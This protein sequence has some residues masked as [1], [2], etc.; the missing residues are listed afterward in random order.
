MQTLENG[1][2]TFPTGKTGSFLPFHIDGDAEKDIYNPSTPFAIGDSNF[3]LARVEGARSESDSEVCLFDVNSHYGLVSR[4]SIKNMQDPY[5]LGQFMVNGTL[6]SVFGGV[7]IKVNSVGEVVSY[8]DIWYACPTEQGHPLWGE[9]LSECTEL[10][11]VV[12]GIERWKDTRAVQLQD[13]VA[14]FPRPQGD[15]G[16]A[17]SI[18]YFE[19]ASLQDVNDDL[20]KYAERADESSLLKGI[21]NQHEWGGVNQILSYDANGTFTLI[22]HRARWVERDGLQVRDYEAIYFE[23]N[24]YTKVV[25]NVGVIATA[26]DFAPIAPKQLEGQESTLGKVVFPAGVSGG[27]LYAGVADRR[28]SNKHLPLLQH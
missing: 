17:G 10:D 18:G 19:S 1:L 24:K 9:A 7:K 2:E 28:I 12:N 11:I 26:D 27:V 8:G 16:G 4:A 13:R 20:K 22:G 3:I 15:F 6:A 23:F 5:H 14:V 25:R 21:F